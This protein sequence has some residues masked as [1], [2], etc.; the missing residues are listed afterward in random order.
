M[1]GALKTL[2]ILIQGGATAFAHL[3]TFI[4][5]ADIHQRMKPST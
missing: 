3:T 2:E 1:P 5:D 4:K